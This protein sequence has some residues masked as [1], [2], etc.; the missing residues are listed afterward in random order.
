VNVLSHDNK[1]FLVAARGYTQWARNALTAQQVTLKKGRVRLE[2]KLRLVSDGEKPAILKA[3]LGRFRRTVQRYFP[4][5]A[6][7]SL[8]A[9]VPLASRYPVFELIRC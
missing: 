9:F 5:A 1:L 3:Y 6:D 8:M 4:V 2:F 7:A